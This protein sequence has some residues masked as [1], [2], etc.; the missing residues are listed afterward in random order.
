MA[1]IAAWV[2]VVI[3]RS[4]MAQSDIMGERRTT[5]SMSTLP[6]STRLLLEQLE[7][8]G[9][10][11]DAEFRKLRDQYHHVLAREAKQG[12]SSSP[13]GAY[14]PVA[15][16]DDGQTPPGS[17]PSAAAFGKDDLGACV[18]LYTYWRARRRPG[19]YQSC[20]VDF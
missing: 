12:S 4:S 18:S 3:I 13:A 2:I 6:D 14:E 1:P 8:S 20:V 19:I 11:V 5:L 15:I 10:E 17:P 9:Q 7:K 16:G